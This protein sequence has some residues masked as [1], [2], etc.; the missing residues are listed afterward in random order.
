[1]PPNTRAAAA[2]ISAAIVN[3]RKYSSVYAHGGG[4]YV[5]IDADIVGGNVKAYDYGRSAHIEGSLPA[6]VYDYTEKSFMEFKHAGGSKIDG[7][8]Y[9][10]S[11]FFEAEVNGD[12]VDIYD[13]QVGSYFQ[14]QV[15]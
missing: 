1:M 4:G 10:S 9:G 14:F 11:S 2:A 7:Y 6:S 12:D 13:Y 15:S 8:H 5:S 3:R